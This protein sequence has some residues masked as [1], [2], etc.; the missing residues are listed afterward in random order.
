MS[1]VFDVPIIRDSTPSEADAPFNPVDPGG[2]AFAG[3]TPLVVRGR[4]GARPSS[5]ASAESVGAVVFR[6]TDPGSPGR[7]PPMVVRGRPEM[8]TLQFLG[9]CR[10]GRRDE[11]ATAGELSNQNVQ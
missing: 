4:D 6:S 5:A 11:A 9:G 3:R 1:R 7:R 10:A 2:I 8:P